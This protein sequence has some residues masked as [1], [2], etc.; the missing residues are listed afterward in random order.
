MCVAD[1]I[2]VF[3]LLTSKYLMKRLR[4]RELIN[5]FAGNFVPGRIRASFASW[6]LE[7]KDAEEKER[8]MEDMWDEMCLEKE[9]YDSSE[10][11]PDSSKMLRDAKLAENPTEYGML[12]KW[13]R[14]AI[15]YGA[16]ACL[17]LVLST[18]LFLSERNSSTTILASAGS[19]A[20]F[21][22]P[23]G[24]S[25]WLNR[26]TTLS[27][28]DGLKG[29]IRK[30]SLDGEAFFDVAKD[31]EH[32]FVV[33]SANVDVKVVGTRFTFSAYTDAKESV[34]L[35]SGKVCL[36]SDNFLPMSLA[37]GEAF[38]YDPVDGSV[39]K[40][41]ENAVNHLSW[42][43]DRLEFANTSLDEIVKNLEHWYNVKIYV[44]E[45]AKDIHLSLTVRQEPL[46]EILDAISRI[47]GLNYTINGN[48]ITIR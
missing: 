28:S 47:S 5:S 32:P 36:Q 25:V 14:R 19:K 6:F 13:R 4:I 17:G 48:E 45:S 34:Y 1:G 23:D 8:V 44:T 37:P 11:L 46:T 2:T 21:E 26:H 22:L 27:Y 20:K 39:L 16:I 3:L 31:P 35:E 38:T 40:R 41:K 18:V 9:Q 7:H 30:V 42:I 29:K 33:S 10:F 15:I 12:L 24:S 43:N